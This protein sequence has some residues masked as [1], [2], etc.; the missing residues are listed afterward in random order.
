MVEVSGRTGHSSPGERGRDA[1]RR[2]ELQDAG[3]KVYE[4]TW[5]DVTRRPAYVAA[6]MTSR[7]TRPA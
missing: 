5:K 2:N 1:Q 7:L 6:T 4:Y 3:R